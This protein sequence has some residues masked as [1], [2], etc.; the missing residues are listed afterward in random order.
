MKHLGHRLVA[1]VI[2]AFPS[3]FR[4]RFG[5]EM[6][7][8]YL[9]QR[10]ALRH[11]ARR[12][13]LTGWAHDIRTLLGLTR[14]LFAERQQARLRSRAL[15]DRFP[16]R[17]SRMTNFAFDLRHTLRSLKASPA[18][19]LV[20]ILTLALGIGA[21]TAV[22]SVVNSVLLSPL[23]YR[24]PDRL[25]RIYHAWRSEPT[26]RSYLDAPGLVDLRNEVTA[27][28]SVGM[29]YTYREI[30]AD[31]RAADGHPERVRVLRVNAEY[32]KTLGATP[33]LGRTFT[34]ADERADAHRVILSHRL[35]K[36]F[37]AGDPS[38]VGRTVDLNGESMEVIGVMRPTFQDLGGNDVAAWTP[39]N[40][41]AG[42]GNQRGNFYLSAVARLKPGVTIAQARAEVNA[43]DAR[44]EALFPN[45]DPQYA[46]R[47]NVLPLHED[48]VGDSRQ[49]LYLLM[50]AAGLVLLIACLNVANLFLSR[51]MTHTRETAVRAALGAGR[52]RLV[53]QRLLESALVA[54]AGGV[55]GSATA[56]WGVK[57]LLRISPESLARSESLHLDP[58]LFGF[59]LLVTGVT[60]LLFGAVPAIR[61]AQAD[62]HDALR[63]VSRGHSPG[64]KSR[65]IRGLLVASQVSVALILLVGA[66]VLI[67][68]F[69]SQMHR[70]L[71]FTAANVATFEINLP[72]SRYDAPASRVRFH[73]QLETRIAAIPGVTSVGAISWLPG[74]GDY[75]D[76]GFGYLDHEGKRASTLAQIRVTSGKVLDAL[77]I[78]LLEGRS[79]S[80]Q[81]N[82]ASPPV[83]MISRSL[84]TK[85]FGDADPIGQMFRTGGQMWTVIGV[86]GD[87]ATSS[88]WDTAPIVYLDHAQFADD[89]NW[90]LTYL[91]KSQLA[92]DQLLQQSRIALGALD[93]ALVLYRPQTMEAVIAQ[94]LARDRFVL[95]LM[96]IFGAV[97]L[98]LA[99]VGVYGV[100]A[101]AVTQR[102][103]EIG[104][105]MALGARAGQ[106]RSIVM[107][108][109]IV[110]AGVGVV[111]GL[112][113]SLALS[114]VLQ[115][116]A[117]N[118][119][120]RDPIVFGGA[121]VVLL[122]AVVLAAYVPTRRAARVSPLE[123]LRGD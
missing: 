5:A 2:D 41:A 34:R 92:P 93:A 22:F 86:T 94:H 117:A 105:R 48:V 18:F 27:F 87:V 104:V 45:E 119:H 56:Y 120:A 118:V 108:Q 60:A 50:G 31:L 52:A 6:L 11:D 57:L 32:F 95:L 101:F 123:V 55:V 102:Q 83:A 115:S 71:G 15:R 121:T 12:P 25:V 3:P 23:P 16:T 112:A 88:T 70:D 13:L 98:A 30:G 1:A 47:S 8:M 63:E 49:A 80:T 37:A 14:A 89:R 111:L 113:G 44:Q 64:R 29:L 19:A 81:D 17:D 103:H 110:V 107:R 78:P 35:W 109:G 116:M 91:V 42:S 97:A 53:G 90:P 68:A 26:A 65:R 75:H 122:L 61:A 43:F 58:V 21:N 72:Q 4:E 66:G 73:E 106:V 100:L 74:N 84:A 24:D 36:E 38:I 69:A 20:A 67:Q 40:L 28:E 76:W 10:D 33:L 85:A 7:S 62:P 114:G 77:G 82:A 39:I 54:V 51:S 46:R 96:L 79:F 9:D 99:A 59:A